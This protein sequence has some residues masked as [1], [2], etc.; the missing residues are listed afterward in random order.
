MRRGSATSWSQNHFPST[1][2]GRTE[3]GPRRVGKTHRGDLG[4]APEISEKLPQ[5]LAAGDMVEGVGFYL[6]RLVKPRSDLSGQC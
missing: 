5:A 1:P 4:P 2:S 6:Q 3:I